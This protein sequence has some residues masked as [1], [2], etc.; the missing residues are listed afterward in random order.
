M[1]GVASPPPT[2][3]PI[4]V[5]E[6]MALR[7]AGALLPRR[8]GR[9]ASDEDC[10]VVADEELDSILPASSGQGEAL[11]AETATA[12]GTDVPPDQLR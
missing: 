2:T 7:T 12:N 5:A 8:E 3:Q 1:H 10:E 9:L 6:G 11:A 4:H